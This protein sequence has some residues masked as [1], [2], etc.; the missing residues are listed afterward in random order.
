MAMEDS[1]LSI[2]N[3]IHNK[4]LDLSQIYMENYDINDQ[5][6]V[7]LISKAAKHMEEAENIIEE[8]LV[9]CKNKR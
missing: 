1:L 6:E 8:I 9:R 2:S 5:I 4:R 7:A 3:H